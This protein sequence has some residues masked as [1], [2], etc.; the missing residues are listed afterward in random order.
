MFKIY[1]Y[2]D[3]SIR[4][5]LN[6]VVLLKNIICGQRG[7]IVYVKYALKIKLSRNNGHRFHE[8]IEDN[9]I[10]IYVSNKLY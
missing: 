9:C 3:I 10:F 2:D 7:F 4:E 1:V 8:Y 6:N 5:I